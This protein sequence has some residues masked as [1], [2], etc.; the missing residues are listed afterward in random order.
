VLVA[1]PNVQSLVTGLHALSVKGYGFGWE[2][3]LYLTTSRPTV[4]LDGME[5][6][7]TQQRMRLVR[8]CFCRASFCLGGWT[9]AIAWLEQSGSAEDTQRRLTFLTKW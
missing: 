7:S 9:V 3:T 1:L 8:K 5:S 6:P 4:A 2:E